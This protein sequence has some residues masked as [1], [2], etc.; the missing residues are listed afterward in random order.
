[1][2][3]HSPEKALPGCRPPPPP[4]SA[5][6]WDQKRWSDTVSGISVPVIGHLTE[7]EQP[8]LRPLDCFQEDVLERSVITIPFQRWS[9]ARRA[10][11][12]VINVS[13]PKRLDA[14]VPCLET[15]PF[16]HQHQ[17][18]RSWHFS[19]LWPRLFWPRTR[20]AEVDNSGIA[21]IGGG[22]LTLLQCRMPHDYAEGISDATT[23]SKYC[24]DP[25]LRDVLGIHGNVD[26]QLQHH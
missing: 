13:T 9:S 20:D 17:E 6:P 24:V 15:T 18:S 3:A 26:S 25:V 23:F 1:M 2:P 10:V 12:Y 22:H 14:G 8:P 11:Q 5:S 16:A 7:R 4:R 21:E 19:A